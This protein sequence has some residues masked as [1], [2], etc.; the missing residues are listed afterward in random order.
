M[1]PKLKAYTHRL[2]ED[3]M[4]EL[5][6]LAEKQRTTVTDLVR[7]AIRKILAEKRP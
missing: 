4:V 3:E 2:Y 6:K 7:V 5:A 1:R